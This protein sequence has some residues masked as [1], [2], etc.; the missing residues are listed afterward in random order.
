MSFVLFVLIWTTGYGF[1]GGYG[2]TTQ[3]FADF[4]SCA[5]AKKILIEQFDDL[6]NRIKVWCQQ[7]GHEAAQ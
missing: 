2:L 7:K 6:P 1:S 3:E 5:F 4:D